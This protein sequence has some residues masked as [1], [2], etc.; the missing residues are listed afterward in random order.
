MSNS[1]ATI[2]LKLSSINQLVFILGLSKHLLDLG[3]ALAFR[4]LARQNFLAAHLLSDLGRESRPLPVLEEFFVVDIHDV[5]ESHVL[6]ALHTCNELILAWS[7]SLAHQL[8]KKL[9]LV[10]LLFPLDLSLLLLLCAHFL[11]L[12]RIGNAIEWMHTLRFCCEVLFERRHIRFHVIFFD[13][14]VDWLPSLAL[15]FVLISACH[16]LVLSED[17]VVVFLLGLSALTIFDEVS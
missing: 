11:V 5:L 10:K 2:A 1:S 3:M 14:G 8:A 15:S 6:V 16:L 12:E 7:E 17:I 9:P 13:L 4:P